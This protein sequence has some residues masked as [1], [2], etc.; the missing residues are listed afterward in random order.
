MDKEEI[1]PNYVCEA[2]GHT[3]EER[4]SKKQYSLF[5]GCSKCSSDTL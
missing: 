2:C 1:D 4:K 3:L 5:F